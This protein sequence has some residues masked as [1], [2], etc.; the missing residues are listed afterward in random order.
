MSDPRWRQ[1]IDF[2]NWFRAGGSDGRGDEFAERFRAFWTTLDALAV[3]PA[4]P[5]DERAA[6]GEMSEKM[7][8]LVRAQ[9]AEVLR[10]IARTAADPAAAAEDR[11]EAQRM[12]AEAARRMPPGSPALH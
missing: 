9:S 11:A 4:V 12:L 6:A 7:T 2:L 1:L 3:D 8:R 10:S 5:A